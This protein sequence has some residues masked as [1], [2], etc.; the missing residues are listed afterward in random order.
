MST[1]AKRGAFA[2]LLIATLFQ[3]PADRFVYDALA[4][5][6]SAQSVIGGLGPVGAVKRL[7][8]VYSN[9][10]YL[11][12]AVV[13]KVVGHSVAGLAVLFENAILVAL[14]GAVLLPQIVRIWG[15][16]TASTI[17]TSCVLTWLVMARF[18]PYPLSD[19]WATSLVILVLVCLLRE[20]PQVIVAGVVAGIAINIRP[21][22]MIPVALISLALLR[23]QWRSAARFLAPALLMQLPQ[24]VY[25]LVN[26]YGWRPWP[27]DVASITSTQASLAAYIVR[28]DTVTSGLA[29]PQLYHCSPQMAAAVASHP[30][31]TVFG[32][33]GSYLTHPMQSL[34]FVLEKVGAALRWPVSA[35]YLSSSPSADGLMALMITGV[36][37]VGSAALL[38]CGVRSHPERRAS[39]SIMAAAW[40]GFVVTLMTSAT[41]TRFALPLI[42]VAIA[43]LSSVW[44]S[45]FAV[46][47][48][49]RHPGWALATLGAFAAIV[50][51]GYIGMRHPASVAFLSITDCVHGTSK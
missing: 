38:W 15:D 6:N 36:A 24:S 31:T 51:A 28:Y 21:A 7:R 9:V 35:P 25:N 12:A 37:V 19:Q 27:R 29:A 42:I 2:S 14:V 40:L 46:S 30:P 16:V 8:G 50:A 41:E 5:W 34:P 4:Y 3:R 22:F 43:G 45:P 23:L 39:N 26:G 1:S 18:A 13:D 49:L 48:L 20:T 33:A 17:W 11:P 10:M 47:R 32:L 44:A